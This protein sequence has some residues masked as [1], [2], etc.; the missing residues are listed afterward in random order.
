MGQ[1]YVE[2]TIVLNGLIYFSTWICLEFILPSS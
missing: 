2:T 1:D